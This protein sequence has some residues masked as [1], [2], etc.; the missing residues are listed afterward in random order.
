MEVSLPRKCE[1]AALAGA[2]LMRLF[3]LVPR[4][5]RRPGCVTASELPRGARSTAGRVASFVSL[6]FD[7]RRDAPTIE[8]DCIVFVNIRGGRFRPSGPE[9]PR[10]PVYLG[11]R[12]ND[13][14]RSCLF[15]RSTVQRREYTPTGKMPVPPPRA[16][17]AADP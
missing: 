6:R 16:T 11:T 9:R 12:R 13:R 17:A 3:G 7:A 4:G 2:P 1:L 10:E 15:E 14:L 8:P 5:R